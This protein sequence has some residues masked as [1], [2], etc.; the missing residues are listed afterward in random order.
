MISSYKKLS[1][2]ILIFSIHFFG[3]NVFSQTP[4][5][6]SSADI[7][8]GLKKLNVL[9]SVLYVA[10]H[11]DDEN[12]RLLTFF[13]KDK[14]YRTGYLSITRGDGGQNLIGNEQGIELGLIR[15]QELLAARRIDGAEQFFTRAY[16]F[17]F[18]KSTDEA[19]RIWDK[20][21]ILSDVVWV[22]RKFQPDVIITRFPQDSRA[23][24]G[25]HSAS[26]VL[27]VE[28]FTVAA[29]PAR[30]PDQLKYV[31]PW[32]A[33]R[34]LWNAGFGGGN[35]TEQFKMEVGGFNPLLGKSN[36]EIASESRSQHKSQGFGV[37]RQRGAS[38][39]SFALWKGDLPKEDLLEG[40]STSWRRI[41]AEQVAQQVENII[42]NFSMVAPGNSVKSLVALYRSVNALP[43][44]YWKEQK[45]REIVQLIEACSGL[46]A[47][48][49][50]NE[51][52]AVQTGSVN[53]S[54]FL[55][56]RNGNAITLKRVMMEGYDS[57][58]N[59]RLEYNRNYVISRSFYIPD[60]LKITQPYWLTRQMQQG[61][62]N[63]S[64]QLL[65]G[66]PDV[67]PAFTARYFLNIEGEDFEITKPVRYKYTD[68]VKGELYQPLVIVPPVLVKPNNNLLLAYNTL[69]QQLHVT[70]QALK[71]T[72]RPVANIT[73]PA[74]WQVTRQQDP[75]KDSLMKGMAADMLFTLKPAVAKPRTDSKASSVSVDDREKTVTLGRQEE[76]QTL[77]ASVTAGGETYTSSLRSIN[78]DHIPDINYFRTPTVTI[79]N[80]DLK[81]VGKKIGYIE[82]AGDYVVTALQQMG[83]DVKI[84]SDLDLANENLS[85]FDAIITGV[86]AYNTRE[87]LSTHYSRLMKYIEG[88]G[89]LIVQYNTSNQL[90]PL[91]AK[92]GPYP[93]NISRTR[94]TDEGAAVRIVKPDHPA[95]HYPN[96]IAAADFENWVQERSIYHAQ[97]WDKRY[98]TLFAMHDPGEQE[99]QGSLIIGKY[100]KGSFVYTGLVFYRELPAGV[101]GAYRLLANL[102]ALNKKRPS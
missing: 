45:L 47:E 98:E 100:G 2:F 61:S 5:S 23:G 89:N 54:F 72:S 101:P 94:V 55:N 4:A 39:E 91:R 7:L 49:T 28:A 76:K 19:L 31:K 71:P 26:A 27:A 92:I 88:G 46:Y 82:G 11:P 58:I 95:L 74:G 37:A 29:D 13:A 70:I 17:G 48:A 99:D 68:P 50:S 83:Y 57:T 16:D 12:T 67:E 9:G 97:N 34:V 65:I 3:S 66:K 10:A 81:T 6:W 86:R 1:C 75:A 35:I 20:E 21:K 51:P 69:P 79:V 25:H 93:F 85:Q 96:K 8:L 64:D 73:A 41:G 87:A 63:V 40:V 102:I 84:L 38:T 30:F 52:M 56:N 24:H 44:G 15:T 78:Y 62:F 90:G 22:I 33:K 59:Q 36:G 14:L 60:T 43:E 42:A 53:V 77:I 80:L 18:S 32:Q